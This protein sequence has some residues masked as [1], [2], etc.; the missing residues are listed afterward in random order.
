[1]LLFCILN[2]LK[3]NFFISKGTE[4]QILTPW[5]LIFLCNVSVLYLGKYKLYWNDAKRVDRVCTKATEVKRRRSWEANLYSCTQARSQDLD[6]GGAILKEW[7]VCKRPWPEFSL[8]LNQLRRKLRRNFSK[9]SE[10]QS[11]FPPKIRWSPK[12]KKKIYNLENMLLAC[13][14]VYGTLVGAVIERS[15]QNKVAYIKF[16]KRNHFGFNMV[17]RSSK[18]SFVTGTIYWCINHNCSSSIT[19]TQQKKLCWLPQSMTTF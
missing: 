9:T 11:F 3:G 4:F 8:L 6:K 12:K 14:T 7:E 13:I 15:N 19:I 10:I 2:R 5:N 17:A 18:W 1:M 16:M